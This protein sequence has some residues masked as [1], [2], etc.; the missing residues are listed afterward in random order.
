MESSINKVYLRGNVGNSRM[1]NVAQGSVIRFSLATTE[2]IKD[3]KGNLI[4]ETQW[5]NVVAW[6]KK[7]MPDF[8]LIDSGSVVEVE[9][10]MRYIKYT[11]ADGIEK[12]LPEVLATTLL[13]KV[14][15]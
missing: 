3:R 11:N 10:K 6:S 14:K 4:E 1:M 9:G 8:S 2:I 13:I 7:G 15:E 12:I 5:H